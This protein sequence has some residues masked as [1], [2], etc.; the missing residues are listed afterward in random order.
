M[1]W[2]F[3]FKLLFANRNVKMNTILYEQ[4]F[5]FAKIVVSLKTLLF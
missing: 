3:S 2:W 5:K 4:R 1:M